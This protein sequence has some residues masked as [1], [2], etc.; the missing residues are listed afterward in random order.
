[1]D[2]LSSGDRPR[3]PR[4]ASA[5]L[6]LAALLVLSG[7][8][9]VAA[10][11]PPFIRVLIAVPF[12]LVVPGYLL[13]LALFPRQAD[14]APIPRAGLSLVGSSALIGVLSFALSQSRLGLSE[15]TLVVGAG[16][17]A[18]VLIVAAAWRRRTVAAAGESPFVPVPS[19]EWRRSAS[20][21]FRSPAALF[22]VA[23][24]LLAAGAVG[25]GFAV[26]APQERFTEL[27]GH[28]LVRS[29]TGT[30]TSLLI[31]VR[32]HE[33]ADLTYTCAAV[34]E[35]MSEGPERNSTGT[36]PVALLGSTVIQ[37]EDGASGRIVV[38]VPS[39]GTSGADTLR[40]VLYPT[41]IPSFDGAGDPRLREGYRN[42]TIHLPAARR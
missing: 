5:D 21:T 6:V 36:T 20:S 2:S 31:E 8:L 14:M 41:E 12:L 13:V 28:D 26:P 22:L 38:P 3:Y 30:N 17:M 34:L 18:G 23:T 25:L 11:P 35:T 29:E 15:W 37:V 19:R 33:G 32:N 9:S 1:M 4:F 39:N 40:I 16:L 24:I 27:V 10:E 7:V 42:L